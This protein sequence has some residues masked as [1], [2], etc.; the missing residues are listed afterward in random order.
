LSKRL[1]KNIPVMHKRDLQ[2]EKSFV[3]RIVIK[4]YDSAGINYRNGN[5]ILEILLRKNNAGQWKDFINLYPFIQIDKLF[6]SVCTDSIIELV[7]KARG[8]D[9]RYNPPDLLSYYVFLF[10]HPFVQMNY[11]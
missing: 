11:Y 9:A 5:D 7:S 4:F 8:L 2:H 3:S 10:R 6:T 1:G